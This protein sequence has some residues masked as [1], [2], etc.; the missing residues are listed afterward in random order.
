MDL[1]VERQAARLDKEWRRADLLR[2]Q[3]AELGWQVIDT[4][5]GPRVEKINLKE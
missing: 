5:D 3:I 1:V 2:G 4:P